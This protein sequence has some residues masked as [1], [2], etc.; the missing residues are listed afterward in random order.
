MKQLDQPAST[1]A[2]DQPDWMKGFGEEP[3]PS[4]ALPADDQ[5]DW[6]K[7]LDQP[8]PAQ[9]A[10]Q[11]DWMKG[12]GEE[13][14]SA[15]ALPADD[16]FDWMKQLDQPTPTQAMDQPDWTKGLGEEPAS[17]ATLPV[18]DQPD[19]MK[20]FGEE[21]APSPAL[22]ADDQPDWMKQP[23]GQSATS[24]PAP[25]IPDEFDFLNELTTPSQPAAD[26][27]LAP[28]PTANV[29]E[30]G[31]S[32]SEIDD[33]LAWFESLAA[34]QGATEGLL[35]KPEDRKDVEP[36]WVKKI[37]SSNGQLSE[38]KVPETIPSQPVANVEELGKSQ[39]EID[40]SLAWFESLAAKQGATE[41]IGRAHV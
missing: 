40:D 19:W 11:P 9:A 17:A 28:A 22:P 26:P 35:I 25:S 34:K 41:E 29:E 39:S 16:Q 24:A 1:Q 32:Q 4:P 10:D 5:F 21:P 23:S 33:S 38:Q 27:T 14:A 20:G 6:M 12:F 31:K 37:K 7:Q 8:A 13:P 18:D 30:L 3:A 2:T 15:S 36:D